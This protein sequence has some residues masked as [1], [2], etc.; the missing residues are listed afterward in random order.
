MCGGGNRKDF[1]LWINGENTLH[2]HLNN[3][4]VDAFAFGEGYYFCS[5]FKIG[6][7][8]ELG[9]DGFVGFAG[10]VIINV[11]QVQQN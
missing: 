10:I 4:F 6:I 11:N 8:F 1:S 3:V 7:L 9:T 2:L 5:I